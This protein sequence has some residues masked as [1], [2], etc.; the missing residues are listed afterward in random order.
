M[1]LLKLFSLVAT[2]TLLATYVKADQAP[3]VEPSESLQQ[4]EIAFSQEPISYHSTADECTDTNNEALPAYDQGYGIEE[5]QMMSAYNSPARIDV[6]GSWDVITKLS[7]IYWVPKLKGMEYAVTRPA[8]FSTLAP[9]D[10]KYRLHSIAQKD[11]KSGFKVALGTNLGHDNWTMLVEY[12][13][14][15]AKNKSS[16][17]LSTYSWV[18]YPERLISLWME[19]VLEYNTPGV[20]LGPFTKLNGHL[21]TSYNIL[22]LDF[23]RP[24]YQ[25]THL[26]FRP[27]VGLTGG[28][29]DFKFKTTGTIITNVHTLYA[30]SKSKSWLLGPR[31]GVDGHWILGSGFIMEGD[32]AGS[33]AYQ[34]FKVNYKQVANTYRTHFL[35]ITDKDFSQIT[36]ILEGNIGLN[37][38]TYFASNDWHISFSALYEFLYY[39][40]QNY[41]RKLAGEI[42]DSTRLGTERGENT[43]SVG[44]IAGAGS[45]PEDFFLHGL[46]ITARLDF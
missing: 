34:S 18:T 14:L 42:V 7:Y 44:S 40:N 11:Y 21:K 26:T 22:N 41:M 46:T 28:W 9:T 3:E 36:P 39:F 35:R 29:I 19:S 15:N 10:Y 38:G 4:E 5:S 13:R 6:V 12:I 20:N 24:F 25:G 27:H 23:A 2:F 16:T 33:L 17:S 37:W 43:G 8:D 31:F 32:L 1:R 45:G 30:K